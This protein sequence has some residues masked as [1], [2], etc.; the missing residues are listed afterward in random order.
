MG[1]VWNMEKRHQTKSMQEYIKELA[2][3]APDK[4]VEEFKRLWQEGK[5]IQAIQLLHKY[6]IRFD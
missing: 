6:N 1:E 3:L 2:L 5:R 4:K